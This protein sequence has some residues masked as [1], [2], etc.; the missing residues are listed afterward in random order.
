MHENTKMSDRN[1]F[2]CCIYVVYM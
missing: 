2:L 1:L